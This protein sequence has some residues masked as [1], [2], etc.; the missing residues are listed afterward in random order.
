MGA[1]LCIENRSEVK[2]AVQVEHITVRYWAIIE[3]GKKAVWNPRTWRRY[4]DQG[5]YTLRAIEIPEDSQQKYKPPNMKKETGKAIA[6]GIML[7]TGAIF[8]PAILFVVP[9]LVAV[10]NSNLPPLIEEEEDSTAPVN[11]STR[12]KQATY[13]HAVE[14]GVHVGGGTKWII[15]EELDKDETRKKLCWQKVSVT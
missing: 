6:S 8:P 12:G 10:T 11:Q 13:R 1:K 3:A 4:V 5:F 14:R 9:G 2:V 7:A 15:T